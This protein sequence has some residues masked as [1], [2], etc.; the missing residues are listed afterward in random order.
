MTRERLG[1]TLFLVAAVLSFL[2]DPQ[3]AE[4]SQADQWAISSMRISVSSGT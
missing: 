2:T 3:G 1:V 4:L